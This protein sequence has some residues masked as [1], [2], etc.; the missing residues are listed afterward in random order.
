MT[1][2]ESGDD[3]DVIHR[4][5]NLGIIIDGEITQELLSFIEQWDIVN[6]CILVFIQDSSKT[7]ICL[8]LDLPVDIFNI[9]CRIFFTRCVLFPVLLF[10]S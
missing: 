5:T 7:S 1:S 10:C 8:E 9:F 6:Y 4:M 3:P 2:H